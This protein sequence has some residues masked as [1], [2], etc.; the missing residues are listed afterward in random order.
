[1]VEVETR[2]PDLTNYGQNAY[3]LDCIRVWAGPGQGVSGSRLAAKFL[4]IEFVF[5]SFFFTKT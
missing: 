5:F 3:F 2:N 4:K 1:M